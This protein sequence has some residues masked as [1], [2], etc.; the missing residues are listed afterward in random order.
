MNRVARFRFKT[1]MAVQQYTASVHDLFYGPELSRL[2]PLYLMTLHSIIRASEPLL[3]AA[4]AESE[5]RFAQGDESCRGLA[6]YLAGH[7][8]EEAHHAE[9]LLEDIESL[10]FPRQEVL[11]RRPLW[12]V[13][14][15]VGSQY[16]WIH[17]YHP[18]LFLGYMV[19]FEGYPTTMAQIDHFKQATGLPDTAFRTMR[20]HT[21]LDVQHS[22][23]IFRFLETSA[24]PDAI[25]DDLANAAIVACSAMSKIFREMAQ[26]DRLLV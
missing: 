10:G 25:F 3:R 21:E 7:V 1:D 17:H 5:R 16:Y 24:L 23:D 8:L 22:A 15:L 6:E 9:W 12:D 4:V 11:A 13:A 2:F 14:A 18:G 19:I 26:Q 20:L